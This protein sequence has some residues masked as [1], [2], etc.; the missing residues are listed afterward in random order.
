MFHPI[1]RKSPI[2]YSAQFQQSEKMKTLLPVPKDE[3]SDLPLPV[4]V[5]DEDATILVAKGTHVYCPKKFY[6]QLVLGKPL[7][8]SETDIKA[9]LAKRHKNGL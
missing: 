8:V 7:G 1:Y 2:K 4:R 3:T 5:P 6:K 9:V